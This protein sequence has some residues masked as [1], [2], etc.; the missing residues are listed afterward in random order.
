MPDP[1]ISKRDESLPEP[2]DPREW[3]SLLWRIPNDI[4]NDAGKI[5]IALREHI[6]ELNCLYGIARLAERFY[7]SMES[8]LACLGYFLPLS[9]Q[10]PNNLCSHCI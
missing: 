4:E 10:Y 7:D 3:L 2:F 6:K 8:F 5:E 1:Q 9:W